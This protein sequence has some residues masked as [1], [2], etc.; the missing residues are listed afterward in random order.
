MNSI[1]KHGL[2][3]YGKVAVGSEV[4]FASPHRLVQMLMDGALEK[5]AAAKG[6]MA[7]GEIAA[8]GEHISW[9]I[10]IIGG[11]QGALDLESGG[12]IARNLDDLYDY[13]TRRLSEANIN[14]DEVILDEVMS[15]ILEIKGAWDA[16]P[17]SVRKAPH[18]QPATEVEANK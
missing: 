16:I 15:L 11:L 8:K 14:N 7:S 17:E 10:S 18:I 1:K 13:M 4:E 12:E 6:Y 2:Q 9:A 3:Q 5:V